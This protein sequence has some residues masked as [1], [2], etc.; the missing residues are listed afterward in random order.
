VNRTDRPHEFLARPVSDGR[1]RLAEGP[2]WDAPRER[3]LWVDID[4]GEVSEGRWHGERLTTTRSHRFD[5]TVGAVVSAADGQLLVAA[6]DRLV[7]IDG[8]GARSQLGEQLIP[9]GAARRLN[10]GKCDPAGRF[11]VGSLATDDAADGREQLWRSEFDGSVTVL[12]DD[13]ALSNGL[14]WSVDGSL[15]YSIDTTPGIVWVRR[16]DPVSG[17]GGD[18]EVHLLIDDGS[19]DGMCLDSAGN[20]WIAIW[21]GGQVRCYSPAGEVLAIVTVP[22]RN[23]TSVAFIGAELDTLL[24]T[25]ADSRDTDSRDTDSGAPDSGRL[26]AADVGARGHPVTPWQNRPHSQDAAT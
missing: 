18:R 26:F 2:V 20:L 17:Q 19:P 4:A 7:V 12:D 5:G 6:G 10:D 14:A 23:T 11:L 25:T 15:F 3:V 9:A 13:L 16:Y 8:S 1:H 24:I 21:G 22:A